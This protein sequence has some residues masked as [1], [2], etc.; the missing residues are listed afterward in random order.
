MVS[1]TVGEADKHSYL[2]QLLGASEVAKLS[3]N[4]FKL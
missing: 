1:V 4:A 2:S 3:R